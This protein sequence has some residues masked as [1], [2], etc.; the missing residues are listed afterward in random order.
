MTNHPNRNRDLTSAFAIRLANGRLW[1]NLG[2][3]S[4]AIF[5]SRENAEKTI[6]GFSGRGALANPTI[7]RVVSGGTEGAR[8]IDGYYTLEA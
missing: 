2:A 5:S 6:R 8:L 1:K 4:A 3:A 7:L